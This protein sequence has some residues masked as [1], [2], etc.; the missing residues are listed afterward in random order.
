MLWYTCLR[1]NMRVLRIKPQVFTVSQ[2]KPCRIKPI[3]WP[4]RVKLKSE[5]YRIQ[6]LHGNTFL[7]IVRVTRSSRPWWKDQY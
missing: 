1:S 3:F 4:V 2:Q 7:G 6:S 5:P